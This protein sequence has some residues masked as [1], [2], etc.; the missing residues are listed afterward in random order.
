MPTLEVMTNCFVNNPDGAGIMYRDAGV[1]H[2]TKGYMTLEKLLEAINVTSE[3]V[4]LKK[5]DVVI[6][7][8]ISTHGTTIPSNCHPFP[9]S[10]NV[11]DLKALN[12]ICGRAIA[13]NG[14]L[15]EYAGFSNAVTDMSDTMY[16]AKMLGAVNDRFIEPV[17]ASHAARGSKFVYMSGHGKTASFGMLKPKGSG[18]YYSNTS[19]LK[20]I[21]TIFDYTPSKYAASGTWFGDVGKVN[22]ELLAARE[23]EWQAWVKENQ[24]SKKM[25]ADR[26]NDP[27]PFVKYLNGGC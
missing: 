6:H 8:R 19:Y 2:I 9:L 18:I 24:A 12:V 20:S 22:D 7:F 21:P 11:D 26:R 23:E 3:T 25:W 17:I 4:N 15:H 27:R 10:N 16:F 13:H 14:I 1:I 5:T